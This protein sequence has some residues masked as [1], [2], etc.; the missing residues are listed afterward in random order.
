MESFKLHSREYGLSKK[1]NKPELINRIQEYEKELQAAMALENQLQGGNLDDEEEESEE[2]ENEDE[3]VNED[4]ELVDV[5]KQPSEES[6]NLASQNATDSQA[7]LSFD[8]KTRTRSYYS[9]FGN[10]ESHD[11]AKNLI[12]EE[13]V[14]ERILTTAFNHA[15]VLFFEKWEKNPILSKFLDHFKKEWIDKNNGWYEGFT[16]GYIPSTDMTW[17]MAYKFLFEGKAVVNYVKKLDAYITALKENN[18][19]IIKDFYMG[20]YKKMKLAFNDFMEYFKAVRLIKLNKENWVRSKCSCGWLAYY[21]YHL[22]AVAKNE[23]LVEIPLECKDVNIE[24]KPP[25]GR[26]PK[27]KLALQ[28]NA[29]N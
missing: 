15:V 12:T 27:A 21:C 20:N 3:E 19:Y 17:K 28:K 5:Y 18:Q 22:I 29:H 24:A 4:D 14:R 2:E 13:F 26:K 10:Y 6:N 9:V 11:E 1:G 25:K 16:D 7:D 8:S 23:G